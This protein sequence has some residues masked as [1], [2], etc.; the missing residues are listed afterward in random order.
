[1]N[2]NNSLL[3]A[4][5]DFGQGTKF[6]SQAKK[7][8]VKEGTFFLGTGTRKS[9]LLDL[10]GINEVR[11][12][13][14]MMAIDSEIEDEVYERLNKKFDLNKPNHGIAFSISLS[15]AM[16]ILDSGYELKSG[17]QEVSE[18]KYEAI[19]TIVN[20]GLLDEVL[21]AAESAGSTGGTVI[22]GRGAN[23]QE[24][25]TLFHIPIEPEK[26]IVLILALKE[27]TDDIINSIK[28]RLN[29]LEKGTGIIFTLEV[30]KA[31]GLFSNQK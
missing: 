17:E 7:A 8:G 25:E 14:L 3:I 11:K 12:E 6:F 20:K 2:N 9:H 18:M 23:S 26:E 24:K 4:I 22:H 5:V 31:L 28:E 10:L 27:K 16:K 21:E 15:R 30:N 1:M 29:I 19:F 13:I